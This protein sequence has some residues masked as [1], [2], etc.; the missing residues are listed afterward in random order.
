MVL[1][2]QAIGIGMDALGTNG[3][4]WTLSLFFAAYVVLVAGRLLAKPRQP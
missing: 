1:G 2:P 4:G 3:F